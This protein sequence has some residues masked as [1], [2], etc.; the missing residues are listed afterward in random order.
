M[1]RRDLIAFALESA[2]GAELALFA[3]FLLS[4][5]RRRSPALYLLAGLALGLAAMMAANLLIGGAG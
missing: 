3:G 4:S 5:P 2:I 1:I